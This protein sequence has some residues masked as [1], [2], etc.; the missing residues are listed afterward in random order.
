MPGELLSVVVQAGGKSR[1][2]GQDKA[3]IPF[4][5]QPL[6]QRV[7]GRV[8]AI[9]DEL[10]VTTNNPA[11]YQLLGIPLFTDL[12]P[13]R[14]ALGGLYT[15]L[16]VARYPLV[17]VVACDMP[18]ASPELLLAER[19]LL[20]DTASHAVIPATEGGSEPFHAVYRRQECLPLIQAA[21]QSGQWRVNSWFDGAR[22]HFMAPEE[23]LSFDPQRLAYW[24]LNT[25]EEL[26]QAQ[27]LAL[28]GQ[29]FKPNTTGEPRDTS[30][31][32][33]S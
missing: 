26:R 17:A 19:D 22:I 10:L 15:A 5:G 12:I 20:L 1:R 18:F 8:A 14:G 32:L 23:T 9:S 4:L 30:H 7:L 25:P 16:S 3:L 2:M 27:E 28:S 31:P 13:G 24:N 21:I 6:I 11:A 33:D 29:G